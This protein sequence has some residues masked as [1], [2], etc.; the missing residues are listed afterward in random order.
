L[1]FGEQNL[2][3]LPVCKHRTIQPAV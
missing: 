2:L 3:I 1:R